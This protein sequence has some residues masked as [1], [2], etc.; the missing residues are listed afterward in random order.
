VI[1]SPA[2]RTKGVRGI[3]QEGAE[4]SLTDSDLQGNSAGD[5]GGGVCV[6]AGSQLAATGSAFLDN[7]A[8]FGGAISV[9]TDSEVVAVDCD[10]DGN[11]PEDV[12]LWTSQSSLDFGEG[13]SFACDQSDCD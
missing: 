12:H 4:V 11:Q 13:A 3:Y 7:S 2:H 8:S 1:A 9:V 10:F 6:Y 5:K